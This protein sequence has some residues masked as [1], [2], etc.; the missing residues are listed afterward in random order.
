MKFPDVTAA[1]AGWSIFPTDKMGTP[2]IIGRYQTTF[3]G[4][5]L[6]LALLG[7][8]GWLPHASQLVAAWGTFWLG[9]FRFWLRDLQLDDDVLDRVLAQTY[10]W[11]MPIFT[12][13]AHIV[14]ALCLLELFGGAPALPFL[15][16]YSLFGG[17][18][19]ALAVAGKSL[20]R[21]RRRLRATADVNHAARKGAA[22]TRHAWD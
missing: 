16:G 1:F 3:L 13:L 17:A 22:Q 15:L 14:T 11:T 8:A 2:T 12:M 18:G 10:A 19:L 21:W 9:V 6:P 7:M 5:A 20:R 4:L